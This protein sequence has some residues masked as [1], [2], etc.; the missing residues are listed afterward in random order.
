[1]EKSKEK[2][3]VQLVGE[4]GNIYNLMAICSRALKNVGMENEAKEMCNKITTTAKSYSE[5]LGIL[6]EYCDVE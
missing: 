5:A 3:T 2:P 4:N 6:M 1:M